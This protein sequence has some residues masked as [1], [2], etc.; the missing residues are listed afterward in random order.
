MAYVSVR[1]EGVEFKALVDTGYDGFV[2]LPRQRIARLGLKEIGEAVYRTADGQ[3]HEA[4]VYQGQVAWF[5]AAKNIAIDSTEGDFSL[6]GM[7]LLESLRL[8]M[9]P[10]SQ[11]LVLSSSG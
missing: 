9:E 5:G 3:T 1:V 2:M 7:K 4:R 6:I 11:M 8:E 10:S